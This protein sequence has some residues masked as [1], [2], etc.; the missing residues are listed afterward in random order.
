MVDAERMSAARNNRGGSSGDNSELEACLGEHLN[1]ET[2]FDVE[3][4]KEFTSFGV[5][6]DASVRHY[7]VDVKDDAADVQFLNERDGLIVRHDY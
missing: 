4:F 6:D 3:G 5:D 1:A 2:V 7:A